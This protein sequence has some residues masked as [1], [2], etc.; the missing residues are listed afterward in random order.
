MMG[1][2]IDLAGYTTGKTA[3]AFVEIEGGSVKATLLRNSAL[4]ATRKSTDN[5][6]HVL[7]E[8]VAALWRCLALAPVAVDVPIDLQGLPTP[9]NPQHIWALTL[10]PIDR[11]VRAMPAFADRIGAPV[12]RFAAIMCKGNFGAVLGDKLFEAYPAAT[13]RMLKIKSGNYKGPKGAAALMSLCKTL[14]IEPHVKS[15]DDIDSIVCAITAAA[16]AQE[17]HNA[18][19][20]NIEGPLPKGFR[21]PKNLTFD[22]IEVG[23]EDFG[24]WMK[25]REVLRDV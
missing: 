4:S 13:L 18:E 9:K 17:V 19:T 1:F 23:E 14:N 12:A 5:L 21:I 24:G 16:P 20:F 15:D 3:L 22:K 11:A 2:G 10:R 7:D 8:E 6:Q 25:N